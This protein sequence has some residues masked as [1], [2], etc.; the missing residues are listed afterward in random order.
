MKKRG[1]IF[2]GVRQRSLWSNQ[3]KPMRWQHHPPLLV[4]R[5]VLTK[6]WSKAV[7]YLATEMM[8]FRLDLTQNS[9]H[10]K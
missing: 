5:Y 7:S 3:K 2:S 1:R 6:G 8:F 4:L 9:D 10:I